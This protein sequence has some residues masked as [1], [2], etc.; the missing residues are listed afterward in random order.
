MILYHRTTEKAANAIISAGFRDATGTYGTGTERTGAWFSVVPF[1]VKE[2]AKGDVLLEVNLDVPESAI[3]AYEWIA[4][5]PSSR[6]W[7][8]PAA[9]AN[10]GLVRR[11]GEVEEERFVQRL[12]DERLAALP[13]EDR[14]AELA[15]RA[16]FR[17][18][19]YHSTPEE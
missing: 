1:D 7:L 18:M 9:L 5:P 14:E 17:A 13:L 4:E 10:S 2:G 15:R 19:W 16:E 6:E 3:E 12:Q 11:V 8:I